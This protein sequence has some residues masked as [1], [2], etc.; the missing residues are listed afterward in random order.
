MTF[1]ALALRQTTNHTPNL[2]GRKHTIPTLVAQNPYPCS[3]CMT[4]NTTNTRH[5]PHL[6]LLT[7]LPT[8]LRLNIDRCSTFTLITKQLRSVYKRSYFKKSWC[9][10]RTMSVPSTKRVMGLFILCTDLQIQ[11]ILSLFPP[12]FRREGKM[13]RNKS[14]CMEIWCQ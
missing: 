7:R 1:R 14:I 9:L 6:P 5:A 10:E 8:P 11:W 2:T 13:A 3:V 4:T 12:P